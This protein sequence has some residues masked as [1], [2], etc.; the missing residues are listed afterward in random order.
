MRKKTKQRGK[1]AF[2]QEALG[3]LQRQESRVRVRFAEKV[4]E[5]GEWWLGARCRK[6]DSPGIKLHPAVY[7]RL[8]LAVTNPPLIPVP[9]RS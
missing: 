3:E 4:Q 8:T 5:G 2:L 7:L 1:K 9:G 6:L